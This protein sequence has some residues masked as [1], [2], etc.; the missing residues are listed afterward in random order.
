[1]KLFLVPLDVLFLLIVLEVVISTHFTYER[2]YSGFDQSLMG[3]MPKKN[4]Q[5]GWKGET[6]PE[7]IS[8]HTTY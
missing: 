7:W 3:Q 4:N 8:M 6:L 2:V 1:M 5:T